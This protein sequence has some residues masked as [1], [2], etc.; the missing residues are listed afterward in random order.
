VNGLVFSSAVI[1]PVLGRFA[2]DLFR[3]S[4]PAGEPERQ[5]IFGRQVAA[6]VAAVRWISWLS[7]FTTLGITILFW[8]DS[9]RP[10]LLLGEVCDTAVGLWSIWRLPRVITVEAA[11]P[12]AR[13]LTILAFLHGSSWAILTSSLMHGADTHTAMFVTS[14]Q[15]GMTAIGFVLYLNLPIAF[16]AFVGPIFVPLLSAFGVFGITDPRLLAMYPLLAAMLGILC[17]FAVDQSR[18]FVASAEATAR[19]HQAEGE[20]QAIRDAAE[21]EAAEHRAAAARHEAVGVRLAEEARRAAMIELAERFEKSVVSMLEAQSAAMADLD[22]TAGKLFAAVHASAD[23]VAHASRR[24]DD[25]SGAIGALAGITSELVGSIIAIRDQVE[26]H[27]TVSEEVERRTAASTDEMQRMAEEASQARG[28]A[29]IIGNLTAQTKLL[30]LNAAIEAARAGDA[31]RGFAVVAAEVKSL[32]QRAGEATGQVAD[33]TGGIIA[34][35]DATVAGM[36][37]TNAHF[38]GAARIAAA[39]AA[40]VHQ[41]RHAAEEMRKQTSLMANNGEDLQSRMAVVAQSAEVVNSMAHN[42][43]ATS[44]QVSDRAGVL[45]EVAHAFLTELR[46]A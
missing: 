18:L 1:R 33:Q 5:R 6:T 35:I 36:E 7:L 10:A 24:S 32:A 23:A 15:V 40:S 31:G 9:F 38:R 44:R 2:A 12:V 34:R 13:R 17:F 8:W 45:R 46:A 39:I 26:E 27:S 22:D 42:V 21:R 20:Q 43:S 25:T 29:D 28:I 37:S 3:L 30:A 19:L 4:A 16:V 41:Q 11:S 14:L